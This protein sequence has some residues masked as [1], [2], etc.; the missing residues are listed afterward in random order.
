MDMISQ[1]KIAFPSFAALGASTLADESLPLKRRRDVASAL[2]S[3]AKGLGIDPDVLLADP[4]ILRTMLKDFTPA[5]AG[6]KRPHWR[7]TLSRTRYAMIQAGLITVPGRYNH[8]LSGAWAALLAG[9]GED[10]KSD[11]RILSRFGRYCGEIGVEPPQV[12]ESISEKLLGDLS[13]RSLTQNPAR[14]HRDTIVRW[15]KAVTTQPGWPQQLLTVPNN[16]LTY[17]LPWESV[18]A[19][20]L[21]LDLDAWLAWRAGMDL[22]GDQD[23][24]L[25]P[26]SL[27][28]RKRQM[29]EYLSALVL[30]GE[31]PAQLT[32]LASAVTPARVANGLGFFFE[33]AGGKCVHGGQIGG[34]VLSI[35]RHWAKLPTEEI[36]AIRRVVKRVAKL[37]QGM[38]KKNR[39]RLRAIDDERLEALIR[40]PGRIRDEIVSEARSARAK[41]RSPEHMGRQS[42]ARKLSAAR[43]VARRLQTAV[44]M[45][46]LMMAPMRLKNL[47]DI[48]IGV[49]LLT[50]R[51]RVMTLVPRGGGGQEW[52]AF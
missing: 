6:L 40:L 47:K 46:I 2:S 9:F 16:R 1:E 19:A 13:E 41:Q 48:Q 3:L 43:A 45:E 20:S 18:G 33:R 23:A 14:A 5:M 27:A 31:D 22:S 11:Y 26:V 28:L 8:A 34:V 29:H 24:P 25:L 44:A 37:P 42:T 32:D 4:A 39:A 49:Q 51:H 7:N 38:T 35:A 15:N 12:D 36:N 21:K 17:A 10:A 50:D 30:R 52:H